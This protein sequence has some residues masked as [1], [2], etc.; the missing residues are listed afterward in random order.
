MPVGRFSKASISVAAIAAIALH[1]GARDAEMVP[2]VVTLRT[3]LF[4]ESEK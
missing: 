1:A 3:M 2:A 4:C